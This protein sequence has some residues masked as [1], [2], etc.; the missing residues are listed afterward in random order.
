MDCHFGRMKKAIANR[1]RNPFCP[2]Q[3]VQFAKASV[4]G[5]AALERDGCRVRH[6]AASAARK[7]KWQRLNKKWQLRIGHGEKI[8][9]TNKSSDPREFIMDVLDLALSVGEQT[10]PFGKTAYIVEGKE[11]AS[12]I[13]CHWLERDYVKR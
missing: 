3:N 5:K 8:M 13:I 12:N 9:E 2:I 7:S 4:D 10:E 1:A 6:V 11:A